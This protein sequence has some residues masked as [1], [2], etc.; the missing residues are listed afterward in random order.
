VIFER[1]ALAVAAPAIAAAVGVLA[2]LARRRRVRAAT[3]WSRALGEQA[4]ARGRLSPWLLALVALTA[5]IAAA[6][7]RWG[8]A[9]RT[10]ESR[11]LNIV[12]V[13]DVSKSMLAQDVAPNR[14]G[15]AVSAARRLVLDLSGDRFALV[16]FAGH[17]YLLS[18][19][20]L[21]ESAIALQLDALDPE[22]ASAGGSGLAVALEL[23]RHT[24][25]AS[26]QGGDRAVVVFTD[27]ES[28]EGNAALEAAGTAL[29]RAGVTLIAMPVGSVEGARIPDPD[30]GWHRDNTGKE[31]VTTRRDD[32]LQIVTTAASGV[33]VPANA[34]D[35]VG[36]ARRALAHLNRAP[37]SDRVA[38]DL[39]PRAWIFALVAVVLLLAQ[40]LTRRT[41]AL[42]GLLLLVGTQAATAQ[43]P[44]TG[45]RLLVHGDTASARQAFTAEARA[46]HSDTAWF[47]AGTSSLIAGDWAAAVLQ[48]QAASVSLD[49]GLRQRALYNLGT[50]N[51]MHARRDSVQRD[52][53]LADAG[54]QL[55][56]ALLL[57]PGDRNAKFNYELTRR[58]RPPPK[59]QAGPGG[60]GKSGSK[61]PPPPPP[62]AGRGGMTPAAAEQVLNAM[63]RAERDTRERQYARTRK[64]EPPVGPD[65]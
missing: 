64:G 53:L 12:L 61:P 38:A 45:N 55:R 56:E 16:G 7:P 58:L 50:A 36:D 35:P 3:A 23:A 22:M 24:L 52:T 15:R 11:A 44:S 37:A 47:N 54:R 1:I 33:F 10:A 18:P 30:G 26:P 32:L 13:M 51:L 6:G 65:W 48:L 8:V 57:S 21:D 59:P 43:R 19:L 4:G 29:R 27:G 5:A 31:V 9:A 20:T 14:L 41:A 28:F 42:A 60:N 63:E 49:P 2:L 39:I 25:V 62:G 40:T 17:A 34:P 46:L